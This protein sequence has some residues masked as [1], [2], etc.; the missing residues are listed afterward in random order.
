MVKM[1]DF[2]PFS[3]A[4]ARLIAECP[5]PDR[6]SFGDGERPGQNGENPDI[7][8]RA[9]LIRHILLGH[10]G[11]PVL[12]EKGIRLRGAHITG[13]LDLQGS[14]CARDI[15]LS[16]CAIDAPIS[17]VNARLRG[18]HLSG[19]TCAGLSADNASFSGSLYIR[20]GTVIEGEVSL[21]GARIGGDLQLCDATIHSNTQ[22]ALFAPSLRVEGSVFLGNYPYSDGQTTLTCD[23]MLFLSSAQVGHDLFV[24][25]TAISPKGEALGDIMFGATEE[26][27]RDM[28][29]SLARARIGGIL[30]LRDN[31]ISGGIVNL[32][33]ADVTRL[34]DEP[35]GPGASYPIRLDGLRY[36]DFSR[37]ADTT[38]AARLEWLARRPADMPFTAQPY[39]QLAAVLTRLGHRDDAR[40]VLMR[41]E[42]L[43]RA[44]NRQATL[45]NDG[46]GLT[47]FAAWAA[48]A[49]L[50]Y[51]IGYG[52]RPARAMVIAVVMVLALG[53]FFDQCWRAGDMTPNAAPILTSAPWIAATQGHPDNP[54]AFWS[55]V[56]EAGQDWETFNAYAYAADLFIPLVSLGQEDAWAPSTSRSPL[57]RTAWWIRW[58]AKAVGWVVTALGAAAITGV[59]RRD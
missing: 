46:Q 27:G 39:E 19:S 21:A 14:D 40:T 36:D 25:N 7:A 52:Y 57:G 44:D 53:L 30:Y 43:L 50:R 15:T 31:Q 8:I 17:L 51:T 41:K 5:G 20:G 12:H 49:I 38:V 13:A 16:N 34:T 55:G 45:V 42:Q 2:A 26:H 56:G 54:G 28:A 58:F 23:G 35:T 11:A 59:I 1:N 37:H 29:L 10:D 33:G 24:T 6:I 4:E 18:L 9:E 22:D 3:S 47:W 48:D 32:A